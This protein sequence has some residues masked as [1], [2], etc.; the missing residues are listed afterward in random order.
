VTGLVARAAQVVEVLADALRA[1]GNARPDAARALLGLALALLA[2]GQVPYTNP[3]PTPTPTPTPQA[4]HVPGLFW[5]CEALCR[6]A[7]VRGRPPDM[8]SS[9]PGYSSYDSVGG[10]SRPLKQ[11]RPGHVAARA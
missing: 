2:A 11:T 10:A 7:P 6:S 8:A 9:R 3:T 5:C 1:V 4:L